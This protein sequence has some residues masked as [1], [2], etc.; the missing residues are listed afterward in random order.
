MI[1]LKTAKILVNNISYLGDLNYD[2]FWDSVEVSD[3][4]TL[5]TKTK[6]KSNYIKTLVSKKKKRYTNETFDLDLS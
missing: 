4:N 6:Q 2:L 3:V 5:V 1:N